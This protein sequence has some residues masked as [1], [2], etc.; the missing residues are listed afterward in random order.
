MWRTRWALLAVGLLALSGCSRTEEVL[1]VAREQEQAMRDVTAVLAKIRDEK[2]MAAAKDEF[3][4][5][6]A[7]FEKIARKA[8][9]LPHPPQPEIG[10]PL[11]DAAIS[12]E[13]AFRE[14]QDQVNRVRRLPGG[15]EFF[16]QVRRLG[17]VRI[18]RKK[19]AWL[20]LALCCVAGCSNDSAHSLS[21]DYRNINNECIDGLMMVTSEA[22][23]KFVTEK[24]FKTFSDRIGPVDK[25]AASYEQNTDDSVIVMQMVTTES[26]AMLFA[27]NK[28][29]QRRLKLEQDRLKN[30]LEFNRQTELDNLKAEGQANPDVNVREIVAEPQRSGG[31]HGALTMFKANLDKGT[32]LA[33][34]FA[35]CSPPRDGRTPC[36]RRAWEEM[37]A[38][39][40]ETIK[41]FDKLE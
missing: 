20:A 15:E 23:A 22:R 31:R 33:E 27:E 1:E 26:V 25:R 34:L 5:R 35:K 19:K 41:K 8:R 9:D 3:D 39:F 4:E 38:A 16:S 14:M 13:K 7:R 2:D 36:R 21:R 18:I 12:M 10:T 32:A 29:N 11:G 37:N 24:I 40:L 17:P 30:L 28:I 6:F